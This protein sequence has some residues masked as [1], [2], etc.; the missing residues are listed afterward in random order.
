[1]RYLSGIARE[2][3]REKRE[4]E[5]F[6]EKGLNLRHYWPLTEQRTEQISEES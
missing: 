4:T 1:M 5:N 2:R 6:P 3:E